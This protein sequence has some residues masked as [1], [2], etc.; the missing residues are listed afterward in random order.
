MNRKLSLNQNKEIVVTKF[1]DKK[2]I[3]ML[4]LDNCDPKKEFET[5]FNELRLKYNPQLVS[6]FGNML[7]T[8]M[9]KSPY[10]KDKK[11]ATI[12]IIEILMNECGIEFSDFNITKEKVQ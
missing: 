9:L 5:L 3:I 7:V 6:F 8:Q 1:K 10:C 11:A 4:N 2:D 12:E